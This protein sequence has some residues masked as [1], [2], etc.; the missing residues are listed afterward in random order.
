MAS[1]HCNASVSGIFAVYRLH[2]QLKRS[3]FNNIKR[4]ISPPR[5]KID[6]ICLIFFLVGHLMSCYDDMLT[7]SQCH[8]PR[9]GNNIP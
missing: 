2:K 9:L 5:K 7:C 3:L 6:K 4:G 8:R 1:K